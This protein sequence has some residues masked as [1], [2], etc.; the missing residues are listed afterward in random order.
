ML[1]T[2]TV[3]FVGTAVMATDDE[4]VNWAHG[5]QAGADDSDAVLCYGPYGGVGIGPWGLGLAFQT[6]WMKL[7]LTG[8][9]WEVQAVQ[10]GDAADAAGADTK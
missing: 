2:T 10:D 9:V 4:I 5:R 6:N 8:C 7:W 1:A 3:P